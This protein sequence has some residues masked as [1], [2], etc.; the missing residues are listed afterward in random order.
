MREEVRDTFDLFLI[1]VNCSI[2]TQL[3]APSSC[4]TD[5]TQPKALK[6]LIG[7]M[8]KICIV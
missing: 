2:D 1:D 3:L 7:F 6:V 5:R 4:A 8:L